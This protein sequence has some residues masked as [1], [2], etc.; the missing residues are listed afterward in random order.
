MA[1]QLFTKAR[2]R[3]AFEIRVPYAEPGIAFRLRQG[4]TCPLTLVVPLTA[5]HRLTLEL[6]TNVP[7]IPCA[8]RFSASLWTSPSAY[9]ESWPFAASLF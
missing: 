6:H 2:L 1:Y 3:I 4:L 9:A 5:A 7:R 8:A